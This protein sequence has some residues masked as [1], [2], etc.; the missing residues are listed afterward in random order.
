M[1]ETIKLCRAE[2]VT[3]EAG[4]QFSR[5]AHACLAKIKPWG[6]YPASLKDQPPKQQK[7]PPSK[8]KT[9]QKTE[10]ETVLVAPENLH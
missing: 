10:T 7:Q 8:Q 9:K 3:T 1:N 5:I 6:S 2:V 4:V